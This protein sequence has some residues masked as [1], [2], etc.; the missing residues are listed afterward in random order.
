MRLYFLG[1]VRFCLALMLVLVSFIAHAEL[2]DEI[3]V[4]DDEINVKGEYS[5]ELHVN[6]TPQ[7]QQQP[8]YPGEWMNGGGTRITPELAYGLG[9]DLEV[10]FYVN[11]VLY[12]GNWD[13]A[14]SK[15]RLKWLPITEEKGDPVFAGLN[16]EL[17]NSLPQYE[18]S[19]YNSEARFILGKHVDDWL[20]VINP[21]FDQALSQPYIHTGPDFYLDARASR[22][23]TQDWATGV[24][25]YSGY[26]DFG[27]QPINYQNTQQMAFLMV[28]CDAGPV[29][30]Q[31]GVGKGI[32]TSTDSLTWKAIFSIPL[33]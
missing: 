20:F 27:T 3:Q 17:S 2:Q 6:G 16:V 4:Y 24:E 8:S 32:S 31:A 33:P 28:Y 9:H 26:A 10:G 14:G 23:I 1:T 18:Q 12:Q 15:V 22:K 30:F 25:Y 29:P 13:Y 19:R 5:L 11:T 21:I 7:A